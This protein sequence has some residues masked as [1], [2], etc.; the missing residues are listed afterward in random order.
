MRILPECDGDARYRAPK[1]A[2]ELFI[3]KNVNKQP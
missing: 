3:A 2:E 1:I